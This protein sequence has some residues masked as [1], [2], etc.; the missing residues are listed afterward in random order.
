MSNLCNTSYGT[1]EDLYW[2]NVDSVCQS[3]KWVSKHTYTHTHAHTHAHTHTLSLSHT[4]TDT[5]TYTHSVF[6]SHTHV[7]KHDDIVTCHDSVIDNLNN[8]YD[9]CYWFVVCSQSCIVVCSQSCYPSPMQLSFETVYKSR[10]HFK[11]NSFILL[12]IKLLLIFLLTGQNSYLYMNAV[13][14]CE[15]ILNEM[16]KRKNTV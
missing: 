16:L 1:V 14:F 6:I 15:T 5:L 2:C 10:V 12:F 9:T 11:R 7:Q 3:I 4:D 13:P 8:I